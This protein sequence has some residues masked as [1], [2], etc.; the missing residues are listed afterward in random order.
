MKRPFTIYA[1]FVFALTCIVI[2]PTLVLLAQ[3]QQWH[4]VALRL[5]EYWAMVFFKLVLPVEVV[6]KE[7]LVIGRQYIFCANHFSYLDIATFYL[8]HPLKFMGKSSLTKIP[9]FGYFFKKIHIPVNRSSARSRA[10]SMARTKSELDAGFSVAFFPEG[11]IMVKH[12]NLPYMVPFKDGAFKI[13]CE[14][15]IPIVPVSMV[16]NFKILPDQS[17]IGFYRHPC[18]VIIHDPIFPQSDNDHEARRMKEQVF[19]IIQTELLRHHPDKVKAV[20]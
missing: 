2:I 15:N 13:A 19:D 9:L 4:L 16:Y 18:K 5:H 8:V 1:V 7:K 3:R 20:N 6:G 17:P 10:K 14:K 12:E 11:G